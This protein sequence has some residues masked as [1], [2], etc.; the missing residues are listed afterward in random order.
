MAL[1]IAHAALQTILADAARAEPQEACGLLLGSGLRITEARPCANVAP[2]P[3]IHFEIDPQALID[4]HR[5]GRA[6][7]PEL[8]GYYHSHPSGP[9]EPSATDRAQAADDGKVWAIIAQ[10]Q[11]RF[12][13]DG[14]DGFKPLSYTLVEA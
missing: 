7:G 4:A 10:G 5:A 14:P 8:I 9:A 6:G 12:W 13:Q 1:E 11:A 2:S 3:E